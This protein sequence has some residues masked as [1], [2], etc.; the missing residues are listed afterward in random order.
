MIPKMPAPDLIR[1]GHR[2]SDTIM[3]KKTPADLAT[4]VPKPGMT[5]IVKKIQGAHEQ[6]D[7][8]TNSPGHAAAP[9]EVTKAAADW[10]KATDDM[11]GNHGQIAPAE[12]HLTMLHNAEPVLERRWGAKKRAFFAAVNV[13]TEY[14]NLTQLDHQSFPEETAAYLRAKYAP[15]PPDLLVLTMSDR[16]ASASL[17]L[18]A[19]LLPP[20]DRNMA[21]RNQIVIRLALNLPRR[22]LG[23]AAS[24]L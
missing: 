6:L 20:S 3:P 12:A 22:E 10:A 23:G 19:A 2:F 5:T 16:D 13:Y 1:G 9:S 8:F 11:E 17:N 21:I 18:A 4:A 7:A 24:D 15:I 14:L